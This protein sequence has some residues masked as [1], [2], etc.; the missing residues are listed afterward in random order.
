MQVFDN[1]PEE[2]IQAN[3]PRPTRNRNSTILHNGNQ[4]TTGMIKSRNANRKRY[5]SNSRDFDRPNAKSPNPQPP[6]PTHGQAFLFSKL[7]DQQNMIKYEYNSTDKSSQQ[8]KGRG[9]QHSAEEMQGQNRPIH[10]QKIQAPM[11]T[12]QEMQANMQ[13]I[14]SNFK[15]NQLNLHARRIEGVMRPREYK[16]NFDSQ[17]ECPIIILSTNID[18]VANTF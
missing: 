11:Q 16:S 18:I 9:R 1:R 7:Q 13:N 10:S 8:F 17:I 12:P 15:D 2:E 6:F 5:H 3:L 4:K 14:Q